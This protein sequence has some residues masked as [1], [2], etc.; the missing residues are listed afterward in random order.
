MGKN[1]KIAILG[2]I[3]KVGSHFVKQSLEKGFSLR[4]LVRSKSS[5]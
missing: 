3:G 1:L 5:F 2:A 4:L